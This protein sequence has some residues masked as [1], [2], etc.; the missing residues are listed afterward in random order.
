MLNKD[1]LLGCTIG[2]AIVLVLAHGFSTAG[3]T[4]SLG[5]AVLVL[6]ALY[7]STDKKEG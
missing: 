4:T 6:W 2:M 7:L 3:D 1:K 5:A